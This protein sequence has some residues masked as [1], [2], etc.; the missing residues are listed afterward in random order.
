MKNS[1]YTISNNADGS[2]KIFGKGASFSEVLSKSFPAKVGDKFKFTIH[3]ANRKQFELLNNIGLQFASSDAYKEDI[4]LTSKVVLPNTVTPLTEYQLEYTATGS[5]VWMLLNFGGVEDTALVDFDIK[6]EVEN[7]TN[8]VKYAY[9]G[10]YTGKI[11]DG[12]STD[13][14][15]YNWKKIIN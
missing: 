7:L 2:F 3:Y 5:N 9:I 13:P 15:K 1:T 12:Q 4:G 14:V 10:T 6:I 11:V 8:P